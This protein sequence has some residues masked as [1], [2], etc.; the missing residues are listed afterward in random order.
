MN[1]GTAFWLGCVVGA[2][3]ASVVVIYVVCTCVP[4]KW[5]RW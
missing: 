5:R 1:A 4:Q 2:V 3:V